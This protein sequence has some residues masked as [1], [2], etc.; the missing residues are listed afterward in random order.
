MGASSGIGEA[1][2]KK[3]AEKG[4]KLVIAARREER[5]KA[6]KDSLPG[7]EI[8][9]KVADVSNFDEV[10]AVVDLA[11]DKFGKIDVIFNNAGTMPSS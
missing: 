1:T 11:L 7:S 4:A 8:E 3:L 5:L 2:V 6:I 9:Y 10:K